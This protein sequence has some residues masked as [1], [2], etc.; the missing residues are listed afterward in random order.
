M[1]IKKT[2]VKRLQQSLK[3]CL[4]LPW[5]NMARKRI[6]VCSFFPKR[7]KMCK[8]I[9]IQ[10]KS[11]SHNLINSKGDCFPL[12]FPSFHVALCRQLCGCWGR[13]WAGIGTGAG[14]WCWAL[15]S[16]P[17]WKLTVVALTLQAGVLAITAPKQ[18]EAKKCV[19]KPVLPQMKGALPSQ[20]KA[21]Q[22]F[23]T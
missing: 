4:E 2:Q 16:S 10:Q 12:G 15:G 1:S 9:T 6:C 17:C 14:D 7:G 21:V 3:F 13:C 18:E 23:N 5:C 22:S 19:W 8:T 11:S 20:G